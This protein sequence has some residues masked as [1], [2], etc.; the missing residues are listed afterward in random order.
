MNEIIIIDTISQITKWNTKYAHSS[1]PS[2]WIMIK[3][4][5]DKEFCL[6]GLI[7]GNFLTYATASKWNEVK[8][9]RT[10]NGAIKALNLFAENGSWGM[11]HWNKNN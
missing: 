5:S 10:F 1:K 3:S 9:W 7:S 2:K 8:V 4:D 6:Y 11:R